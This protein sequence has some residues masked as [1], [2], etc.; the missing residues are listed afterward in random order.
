MII[1]V[2]QDTVCPWCRIGKAHL[3]AALREWNGGGVDVRYHPFLLN[4]DIPDEGYDFVEYMRAKGGGQVPLEQWFERPREMG[5]AIGVRFAFEWITR[6]PNS[7]LSHE[8]IALAPVE[9]VETVI[10]AV[11]AAYFERGLDIGQRAVLLD[12]AEEC[13]LDGKAI[14]RSL[15]TRELRDQVRAEHHHAHRL[16]ITG[17]PFFVFNGRLALSGAQPIDAFRDALHRAS[18]E[19][20]DSRTGAST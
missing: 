16:G 20:V 19:R 11:Y 6:A 17:V 15:R 14:E 4:P 5:A 9:K 10:D 3:A 1:D 8:L 12:I 7:S 13:R 2:Y 18:A